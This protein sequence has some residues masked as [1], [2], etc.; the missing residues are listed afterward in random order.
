MDHIVTIGGQQSTHGLTARFHSIWRSKRLR[1][2]ILVMMMSASSGEPTMSASALSARSMISDMSVCE[3]LG[4]R[5]KTRR[6]ARIPPGAPLVRLE[7]RWGELWADFEKGEGE[8]ELA[9]LVA[10]H[11]GCRLLE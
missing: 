1:I 9:C 2:P 7:G 8:R 10:I 4:W 6:E 3:S 5:M 11:L